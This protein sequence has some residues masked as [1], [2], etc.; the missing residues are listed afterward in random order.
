ML[1]LDMYK[2]W[3]EKGDYELELETE[4]EDYY[5]YEDKYYMFITEDDVKIDYNFFD[6]LGYDSCNLN[7]IILNIAIHP[8]EN[9][10]KMELIGMHTG[11]HFLEWY[12]L[13]K[14]NDYR[15]LYKNFSRII[16]KLSNKIKPIKIET[17]K[18]SAYTKQV[19]NFYF[20]VDEK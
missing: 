3:K 8:F 15:I 11:T 17:Y 12:Y 20:R 13:L 19:F 16:S 7:K 10:K 2:Y 1:R 4:C 14:E 5:R 9:S 18:D 6:A